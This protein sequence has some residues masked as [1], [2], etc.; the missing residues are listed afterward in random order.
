MTD[1]DWTR[2]QFELPKGVVYLDGNSLGPIPTAAKNVLIKTLEDEWSK[3]LISAWNDA[4]WMDLPQKIGNLVAPIINVPEETI[5]IGDTLSIKLF[6]ALFSALSLN[7]DRKIILTDNQNFPS[8][9]YVAKGLSKALKRDIT[10][11]VINSSQIQTHITSDVAV[12]MLTHVNYRTG[13]VYNMQEVTNMA[14]EVGAIMLWDLA[15]SAGAIP[16][17]LGK[18]EFAVGCTYKFLNGGPGAPAFIYARPDLI[19]RCDTILNGW[20]GHENPFA[21]DLEFRPKEGIDRFRVGTPPILQ[22][23]ALE[24][25]LSIWKHCDIHSIYSRAQK[26]GDR[27]LAGVLKACPDFKLACPKDSHARGSQVSFAFNEAYPFVQALIEQGVVGDFRAPN[28]LRFGITPLYI[29]EAAIN[30]AVL[31]FEKIYRER[32]WRKERFQTRKGVT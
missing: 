24:A 14:H 27:L 28:I 6:Q 13:A 26:L 12:V 23:R 30:N 7:P 19:S 10:V 1:F 21:F 31:V 17:T 18:S 4:G 29:D 22:L 3:Q 11:Q 32:I 15:H 16:I 25:A 9:I 8:D 20:L 2:S 5:S